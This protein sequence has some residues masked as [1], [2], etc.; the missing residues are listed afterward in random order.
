[1]RVAALSSAALGLVVVATWIAVRPPVV[2]PGGGVTQIAAHR[3]AVAPSTE[4]IA[5]M[6]AEV[7]ATTQLVRHTLEEMKSQEQTRALRLELSQYE[8][9]NTTSLA[10]DQTVAIGLADAR[11]LASTHPE[12]ARQRLTRLV[13]L[14]PDSALAADAKNEL[15]Q[16]QNREV[17]P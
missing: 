17:M 7:D 1:M 2:E 3:I 10:V 12:E 13:E 16:L 4:Q 9:I 8:S 6:S 5:A 14:F 11:R 15:H